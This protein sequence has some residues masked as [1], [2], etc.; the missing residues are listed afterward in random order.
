MRVR[1]RVRGR[2]RARVRV[3]HEDRRACSGRACAR[4]NA[5]RRG[6]GSG[7]CGRGASREPCAAAA[8]AHGICMVHA[9]GWGGG[10]ARA[11]WGRGGAG[12]GQGVSSPRHG[13]TIP[14]ISRAYTVHAPCAHLLAMPL[15]DLERISR[16]ISRRAARV[17]PPGGDAAARLA[18]PHGAA[19]RDLA[20]LEAR[21]LRHHHCSAQRRPA[22]RPGPAPR[23]RARVRRGECC[24]GRL[25]GRRRVEHEGASLVQ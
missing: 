18:A 23:R 5:P 25:A 21:V 6:R 17:G 8:P 11:G 14:R 20:S 22:V 24:G 9:W 4:R 19:H 1:G 15:E 12:A 3:V 13:K 10:E 16:R 2:G 7:A